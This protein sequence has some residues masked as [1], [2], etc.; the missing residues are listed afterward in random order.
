MTNQLTKHARTRLQQRGIS[1][2]VL[3]CL[4]AYGRKVHDHRGGEV[5]FFDH[6]SRT[7]LRRDQG[8]AVFKRLETKLGTYAVLGSDGSIITV[9]HRTKRISRH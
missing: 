1:A 9:G 4:L 3:D 7:Q 6:H 5:I 2:D 8:D